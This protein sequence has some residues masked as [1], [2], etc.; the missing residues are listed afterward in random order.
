VHP[1]LDTENRH[2]Q[3]ENE[4]HKREKEGILFYL[5]YARQLPKGHQDYWN[6][7]LNQKS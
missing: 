6:K 2:I 7:L 5:Q 4:I 1:Q 3:I